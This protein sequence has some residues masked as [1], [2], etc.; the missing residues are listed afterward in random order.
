MSKKE[1]FTEKTFGPNYK[2]E[3]NLNGNSRFDNLIELLMDKGRDKIPLS[4]TTAELLDNAI[5]PIKIS[6]TLSRQLSRSMAKA[7]DR[8]QYLRKT[9]YF[10]SRGLLGDYIAFIRKEQDISL[11]DTALKLN[12]QEDLL[13]Y[14]ESGKTRFI[15]D[16]GTEKL[17]GLANFLRVSIPDFI[18]IVER[19]CQSLAKS[20][21]F[22][23]AFTSSREQK[24]QST[25]TSINQ[26]LADFRK[27]GR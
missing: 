4:N 20:R 7:E 6:E 8:R 17:L 14:I 19:T 13:E 3:L 25:T 24:T 15:I 5:E 2:A 12:I 9:K 26:F 21:S 18:E 23:L 27:T 16:V 11:R 1:E 22:S 10:V